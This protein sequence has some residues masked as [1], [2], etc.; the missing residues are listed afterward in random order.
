[1]RLIDVHGD[2]LQFS[3][4]QVLVQNRANP[5]PLMSYDY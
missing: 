5:N 3:Q 2:A 4:C 1:M